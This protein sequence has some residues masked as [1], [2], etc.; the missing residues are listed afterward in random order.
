[1]RDG[2][3][4]HPV[5]YYTLQL[6]AMTRLS[7][8]PQRGQVQPSRTRQMRN[9]VGSSGRSAGV[10]MGK[11]PTG[12]HDA[13]TAPPLEALRSTATASLM[14]V[15]LLLHHMTGSMLPSAADLTVGEWEPDWTQ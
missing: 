5:T 1:M 15:R 6:D 4:Y 13:P 9:G 2:D 7:A 10:V 12:S 8:Q 14:T 3:S 11:C